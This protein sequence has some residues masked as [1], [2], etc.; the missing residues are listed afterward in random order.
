MQVAELEEHL[1]GSRSLAAIELT[2]SAAQAAIAQLC[3][4]SGDAPCSSHAHVRRLGQSPCDTHFLCVI[5]N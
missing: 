2:F 3:S 5:R 4:S 1:S